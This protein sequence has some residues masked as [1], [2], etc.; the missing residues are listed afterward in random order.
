MVGAAGGSLPSRS[1]V[2]ETNANVPVGTTLARLDEGSRS[3]A[4]SIAGCTACKHWSSDLYKI[5]AKTPPKQLMVRPYHDP[6]LAPADFG[7]DINV[8][9]VSDPNTYSTIQRQMKAQ[10]R[11]QAAIEAAQLG[12]KVNMRNAVLAAC[13]AMDLPDLEELFPEDPQPVS[14]IRS[15]RTCRSGTPLAAKPDNLHEEH[16]IVHHAMAMLPG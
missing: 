7:P 5:D 11:K 15:R 6:E 1:K 2:A 4:A 10:A 14:P 16:L 12:V 13:E 9:P 3:T 8:A